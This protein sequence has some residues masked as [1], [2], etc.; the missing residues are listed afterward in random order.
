M[1]RLPALLLSLV[2][3]A[4]PAA[5]QEAVF[6]LQILHSSDNES[7]F[8]DPVTLEPRLLHYAALVEGLR[9]LAPGGNSLHLTAGDHSL[10]GPLYQ[11]ARQVPSLGAP[12]LA[13]IA[14]FNAMGLA[15]NGIGNHEFDGGLDA[16]AV[17]LASARYPFIA[18]NLDFSRVRLQPGTPAIRI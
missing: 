6:S 14:F 7:S 5:A 9:T 1:A 12:G 3:L 10:P 11:A 8:I 17:M 2:L 4:M 16:F 15:A 18:A 13:D